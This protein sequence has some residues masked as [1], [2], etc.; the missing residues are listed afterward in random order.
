MC[1][2]FWAHKDHETVFRAVAHLAE[3]GVMVTVVCTGEPQDF[4]NPSY[5]P[6][7]QGVVRELGID[8]QIVIT[9]KVSR[10][11]QILLMCHAQAVI[12][13]SLFEGWSTVLEDA[14]ALGKQ[15]IASDFPVHLEQ[16]LFGAR[17]F[18]Q[19]D[20]VDLSQ[21][22]GLLWGTPVVFDQQKLLNA[23]QEHLQLV[24]AGF[25]DMLRQAYV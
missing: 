21:H 24:S 23:N 8:D 7:L 1:N 14:R 20:S 9:G 15:V 22:L 12:Q 18:K 2:Q 6:Y 4:R 5:F 13:P 16:N 3:Q 19:R 17:Y 25:K 11:E 10:A